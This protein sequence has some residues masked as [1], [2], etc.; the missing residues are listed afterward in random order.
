VGK[1]VAIFTRRKILAGLNFIYCIG[2]SIGSLQLRQIRVIADM[3]ESRGNEIVRVKKVY[4]EN[5]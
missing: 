3:T 5:H 1:L 2:Y 4:G